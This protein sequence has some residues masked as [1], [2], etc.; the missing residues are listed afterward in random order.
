MWLSYFKTWSHDYL[1]FFFVCDLETSF[2]RQYM[3]KTQLIPTTLLVKINHELRD[4]CQKHLYCWIKY[5][6]EVVQWYIYIFSNV[7]CSS[8]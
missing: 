4:K 6:W 5:R 1:F 2:Y 8:A 3:P 7:S